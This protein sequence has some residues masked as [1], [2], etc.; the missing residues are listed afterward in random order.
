[1]ADGGVTIPNNLIAMV[2][3]G[4]VTAVLTV[5]GILASRKKEK[6]DATVGMSVAWQTTI[7]EMRTEID[8]LY[9]RVDVLEERDSVNRETIRRLEDNG[10]ETERSLEKTRF[11][12]GLAEANLDIAMDWMNE[13][14]PALHAAGIEPLDISDLKF[15]GDDSTEDHNE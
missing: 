11:K 13:Y 10:R 15:R 7:T 8:R 12:L 2:I 5:T 6:A 3:S 14:T 1:M 9:E 4:L